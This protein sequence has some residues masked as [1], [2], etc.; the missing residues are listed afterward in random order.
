MLRGK[1]IWRTEV[2]IF[3]PAIKRVAFLSIERL[4]RG[5]QSKKRNQVAN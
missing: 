4:F 5:Y 3:I 2:N 1:C